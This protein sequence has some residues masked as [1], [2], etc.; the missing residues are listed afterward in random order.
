[1]VEITPFYGTGRCS[2]QDM[3]IWLDLEHLRT[4][5]SERHHRFAQ[6]HGLLTYA[7]S[8]KGRRCHDKISPVLLGNRMTFCRKRIRFCIIF[9]PV[10]KSN[11]G[12]RTFIF[13]KVLCILKYYY[14]YIY[15]VDDV[16]SALFLKLVPNWLCPLRQVR[17]C[18]CAFRR[19]P[20]SSW[21]SN[22]PSRQEK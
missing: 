11:S 3:F 10:F 20:Q 5:K 21:A 14:F 22:S 17:G 1:M 18:P 12:L 7:L 19:W 6:E 13:K 9:L 2:D 16:L 4:I 8:A 15:W